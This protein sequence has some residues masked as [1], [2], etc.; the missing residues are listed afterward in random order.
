M[1]LIIFRCIAR[2]SLAVFR[3]VILFSIPQQYTFYDEMSNSSTYICHTLRSNIS[4]QMLT[5]TLFYV[6]ALVF[7]GIISVYFMGMNIGEKIRTLRK[8]RGLSPEKL[9]MYA[10][11]SVKRKKSP[12]YC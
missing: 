11:V 4:S 2:L 7:F 12:P 8:M 1:N 9:G 6:M 3:L 5:N 10:D